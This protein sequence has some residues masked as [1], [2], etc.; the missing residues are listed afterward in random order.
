MEEVKERA[1]SD[2]FISISNA[3]HSVC[4]YSMYMPPHSLLIVAAGW[5][6]P[7]PV[8]SKLVHWYLFPFIPLSFFS[9]SLWLTFF[10]CI[11]LPSFVG[12]VMFHC[13]LAAAAPPSFLFFPFHRRGGNPPRGEIIKNKKKASLLLYTTLFWAGPSCLPSCSSIIS[14][15]HAPQS[16]RCVTVWYCNTRKSTAR[17]MMAGGV[18]SPLLVQCIPRKGAQA[19]TVSQIRHTLHLNVSILH[20]FFL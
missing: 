20:F 14:Y 5:P 12:F 10:Y 2:S 6:V 3:F 1:Q 8:D 15:R 16:I 18:Q 17:L 13:W 9:L 19:A 11:Q 7:M 4:V